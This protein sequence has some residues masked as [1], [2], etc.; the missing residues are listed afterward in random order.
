[1]EWGDWPNFEAASL[2]LTSVALILPLGTLA[3]QRLSASYGLEYE[4]STPPHTII[5]VNTNG[6]S[7]PLKGFSSFTASTRT[8]SLTLNPPEV[9]H[10]A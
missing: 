7:A 9:S 5:P 10:T 1:M 6:S 4:A 2:T 8:K 3:A